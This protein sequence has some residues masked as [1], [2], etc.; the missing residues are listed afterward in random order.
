[1][2]L[3]TDLISGGDDILFVDTNNCYH[4]GGQVLKKHSKRYMII[5]TIGSITHSFNSYFLDRRFNFIKMIAKSMKIYKKITL[6]IQM[7]FKEKIINL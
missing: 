1:M 2:E 7:I 4:K 6:N 5:V 3:S